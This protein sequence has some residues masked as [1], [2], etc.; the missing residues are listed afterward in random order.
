MIGFAIRKV[1]QEGFQSYLAT[2]LF[3]NLNIIASGLNAP[4]C[5]NK[6]AGGFHV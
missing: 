6:R 2:I 4:G 3:K 1:F 5:E